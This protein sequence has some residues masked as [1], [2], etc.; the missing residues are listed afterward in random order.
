LAAGVATGATGNTNAVST[1]TDNTVTYDNAAPT[2]GSIT[3]TDGYQTNTTVALTVSD[4][5]DTGSGIDTSSRIVQR[6][7]ATLTSGTCGGYGSWGT[8]VTTGTY[9]TLTDAAVVPVAS[10]N[11]YQYQYLISDLAGNQ[12]TYTS[13]NTAKVDTSSP[14]APG[15]PVPSPASPTNQTSQTWSW[16]AAT[17]TISG[18]VSYAWRTTGTAIVSGTTAV[19][20]VVTSLAQGVYTFFVK[21]LS[22][23]G[24][25]GSESSGSLTVD[26]TPPTVTIN[27]ASGQVDPTNN[28]PINF[29]VVFSESVSDFATGDVTLSGTAGATT[30]TVTGSGTTYNVAVGGMTGSGSVIASLASGVAHDAAGNG[31]A[32]STFTDNFVTYSN[33]PPTLTSITISDTSEYTNSATPTINIVSSGSPTYVAFSCNGGTNWSSWIA[34]S[35]TISSFNITSGA[36]GCTASDGSKTITAKLKDIFNT[37]SG[38]AA[39][40]TYYDTTGPT[41]SATAAN[42]ITNTG[43]TITWTTN[44]DSSSKVDYGL[45]NTYGSTTSETNTAPGVTSHSV[46]LSSLVA[47]DSASYFL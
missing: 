27:Q 3:Y 26:T 16:T 29:T 33:A 24:S 15:T 47:C 42:S 35:D 9:P 43:A 41:V 11:C 6:R 18:I 36:T 34:Y 44:I 22:G 30:G 2:G 12:A 28:S 21:A 17:D 45:V 23:A 20:N 32:I 1:S 38:L 25:Y 40:T 19:T 39:D 13:T 4:G 37:E 8:I 14:S 46:S 31:N 5:T 7:S 10:G